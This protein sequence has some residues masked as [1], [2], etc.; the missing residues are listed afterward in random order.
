MVAILASEAAAPKAE[1]VRV[2]RARTPA[3]AAAM[4]GTARLA[5]K[6][7]K[8]MGVRWGAVTIAEIAA[9]KKAAAAG[10]EG[11]TLAAPVRVAAAMAEGGVAAKSALA[12]AAETTAAD[13][14]AWCECSL[15]AS[16]RRLALRPTTS[17]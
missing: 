13:P 2:G 7:A 11:A 10:V 14:S 16:R 6:A 1:M 15:R 9:G 17:D 5:L 8:P 3:A 12:A 4:M